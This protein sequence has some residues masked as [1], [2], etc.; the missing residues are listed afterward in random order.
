M[1]LDSKTFVSVA[2]ELKKRGLKYDIFV[3]DVQKAIDDENKGSEHL[4]SSIG[5]DYA[6]YNTLSDVCIATKHVSRYHSYLMLRFCIISS[7]N[8]EN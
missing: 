7:N 1:N 6:K 8:P 3:K 5:F 2:K 4:F